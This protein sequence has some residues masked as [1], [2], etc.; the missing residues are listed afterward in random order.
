VAASARADID[1]TLAD[2]DGERR[3]LLPRQTPEIG[4]R[5]DGI[6]Q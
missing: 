2:L 6:Q 5:F 1:E 4:R 3:K